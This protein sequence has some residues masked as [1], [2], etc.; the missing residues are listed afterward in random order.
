MRRICILVLL[1]VA[2]VA[3]T[4][5]AQPV[6]F[7]LKGDVAAGQKPVL[8]VTA[9]QQVTDLRVELKRDDGKTFTM[10]QPALARGAS[11]MLP[12]GDG[13]AGKAAYEGTISAQI[14]GGERWS[15]PLTFETLVRVPIKVTYDVDHLDLDKRELQ[16]QLS[17]PAGSAELV[18]LGEDGKELGKGAATYKKE[19]PGTWLSISWT[20]PAGTRVMT[21]KLRAVSA[22]GLASNVELIPWSVSIEHEDVNFAT[23]SAVIDTA[24]E[25]KL[26]A[27]LGKIAEV[28]KRSEK[29]MKMRLYVAGHTDTVGPD[30]KNRKLSLD[31]ARAIASYFRKKG[32]KLPIAFA[33]YGESVLKVKTADNVDERANRRA[34]YVIGPAAGAPPFK[35]AYLKAQA[36]WQQLP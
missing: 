2:G 20:Q 7:E 34:D 8:R 21:M 14:V 31:R 10:R 26:D 33:G 25:K 19:A 15:E 28:V 13:A 9:T 36:G 24:E 1:L 5:G 16:F 4:A 6:S 11:V 3:G 12:V 29:F 32:V 18:V 17:R 30:G 22:D 23:D 27:S 35:G